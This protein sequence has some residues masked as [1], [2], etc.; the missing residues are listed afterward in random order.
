[1]QTFDMQ[2]KTRRQLTADITEFTLVPVADMTLPGFEPGAHITV[3]TP[4]GAMRRYSLINDGT[5]PDCYVIAV[6]RDE[7]GRGGSTS[8]HAGAAEGGILRIEAPQNDFPLGEAP[9]YLLI[10]G[11]IGITPIYAM[12]RH[13][14]RAGKPVRIVYCSRSAEATAFAEVLQ[15][16]FGEALT[17]HHDNGDPAQVYDFWDH[18]EEP[19]KGHVYCCGP[20]ALMEDVEALSGHWPEGAVNFETFRPVEVVRPDDS[21]FDVTL[22]QSGKT[23]EV[24]ADLSILEALRANGLSVP[25]SCESGTCGTCKCRLIAG[26]PDH[27]DM[28]LRDDERDDHIMICVSRATGGGLT[29]DL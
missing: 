22:A 7:A 14:K 26:T 9:E 1:M 29:I 2:V 4:S 23:I 8:M 15:D 5:S 17:L 28:V 16:E 3:E 18:F 12:A 21:A 6:K 11:G 19:G 27:R 24:P 20:A 10:A 13:L 25:S